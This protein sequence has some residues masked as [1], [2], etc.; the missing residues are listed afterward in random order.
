MIACRLRHIAA[1][2]ALALAALPAAAQAPA[3]SPPAQAAPPATAANAD[4]PA[5]EKPAAAAAAPQK[6]P[7]AAAETMMFTIDEFND[8]QGR[9]ASGGSNSGKKD[10]AAIETANLYLST[11][12]YTNRNDWTVWIN[13]VPIGPSQDFQSFQITSI[14]PSY[15]E[16]LVPLSAQGMRPVKL[17]PNQTFIA[18]SG[19]VVEGPVH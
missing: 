15:V 16:L 1:L 9:I 5:T 3:Q 12:L 13:G 2:L 14:T 6:P 19:A 11:I 10:S 4:K 7:R 18:K 8:I 17:G